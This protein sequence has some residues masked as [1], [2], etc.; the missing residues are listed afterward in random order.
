MTPDLYVDVAYIP[1]PILEAR[2]SFF[3]LPT[4]HV[5]KSPDDRFCYSTYLYHGHTFTYA[6]LRT[7]AERQENALIR[8]DFR[9]RYYLTSGEDVGGSTGKPAIGPESIGKR[10]EVPGGALKREQVH[11]DLRARRNKAKTGSSH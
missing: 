1:F 3:C 2:G 10:M 6:A 7:C 8:L 4:G 11:R 5:L 9:R